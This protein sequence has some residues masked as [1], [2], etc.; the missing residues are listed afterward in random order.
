MA[1]SIRLWENCIRYYKL[2]EGTG[3]SATDA[4]AGETGTISG[5]GGWVTD[6]KLGD[7]SIDLNT[8]QVTIPYSDNFGGRNQVSYCFWLKPKATN[9]NT[10]YRLLQQE[11]TNDHIYIDMAGGED[12]YM[13]VALDDGTDEEFIFT[14]PYS[15]PSFQWVHVAIVFDWVTDNCRI[16]L[17]GIDRASD[18]DISELGSISAGAN[19][20]LGP[21]GNNMNAYISDF[22]IFN[23]GLTADEV[24]ML[25][26]NG[27]GLNYNVDPGRFC[28]AQDAIYKAGENA[29][30][31]ITG[32]QD[33]IHKWIS[34]YQSYINVK[35]RY[36]FSDNWTNLNTDVRELLRNVTSNLVA[37]K[38]ISYNMAGYTSRVE[39]ETIIDVLNND[40][41]RMLNI[42]EQNSLTYMEEA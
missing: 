18:P 24:L 5:S 26:N 31:T 13:K 38:I 4:A 40:A 15:P 3:T 21:T 35:L 23:K 42:L 9:Y 6:A 19:I 39:A 30:A 10:N 41:E 11:L 12:Y 28:S 33:V 8:V 17:N 25:Y 36:N 32:K 22:G 14:L 1:K 16:Y 29:D 37:I 27:A 20:I 34:E 7:Y 2:D